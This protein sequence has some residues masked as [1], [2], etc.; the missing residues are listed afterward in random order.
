MG[1]TVGSLKPAHYSPL[2]QRQPKQ[3]YSGEKRKYALVSPP[4]PYTPYWAPNTSNRP[5]SV[6]RLAPAGRVRTPSVLITLQEACL[7]VI[8]PSGDRWEHSFRFPFLCMPRSVY[9]LLQ[10]KSLAKSQGGAG[11]GEGR[12]D[13]RLLMGCWGHAAQGGPPA[14]AC[15]R[16]ASSPGLNQ[17][18]QEH[19][20]KLSLRRDEQ[21]RDGRRPLRVIARAANCYLFVS[22]TL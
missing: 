18:M 2:R 7:R 21:L 13:K 9:D 22:H 19:K 4:H 8:T 15:L 10:R 5:P 1:P 20:N 3:S 17:C 14:T 6:G 11:A 16:V 12:V